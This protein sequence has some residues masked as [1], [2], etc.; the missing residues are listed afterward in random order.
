[1]AIAELITNCHDQ[2]QRR[3][4]TAINPDISQ[5]GSECNH[6]DPDSPLRVFSHGL[7]R[8]TERTLNFQADEL[9]SSI[10]AEACAGLSE[11]LNRRSLELN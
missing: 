11:E 7:I 8:H 6:P 1:V 4:N 2:I 3:A 9:D 10:V 5:K